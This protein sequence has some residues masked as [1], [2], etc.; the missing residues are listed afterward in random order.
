MSATNGKAPSPQLTAA[1]LYR[2]RGLS[3]L[4]VRVDGSK[5]PAVPSWKQYQTEP[6]DE[7]QLSTWFA[8]WHRHGLGIIGGKVSGNLLILDF[9]EVQLYYDWLEL[10]RPI[11]AAA[12]I[13]L[14][15]IP[16]V[17]T[18]RPGVHF[19][20]RCSKAVAG[21]EKLALRLAT[22]DELQAK[23]T[24]KTK[25]LIETR[26]EGG[27]VVAPGSPPKC[28]EAGREYRW[29]NRGWMDG[30]DVPEVNGETLETLLNLARSLDRQ[31]VSTFEPPPPASSHGNALRPGDDF[32]RRASWGDVLGPIG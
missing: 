3:S 25:T 22:D 29:L 15:R 10:A 13:P 18:P 27:Y 28:H 20:L 7:L 21:N 31:P 26:G 5:A 17:E 11:L 24:E 14:E 16:L 1:R 12:G 4:P 8:D 30:G 19:Y 9:E 6:A 32:N 23:P 2:L